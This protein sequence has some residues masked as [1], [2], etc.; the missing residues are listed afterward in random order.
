MD[1]HTTDVHYILNFLRVNNSSIA[2]DVVYVTFL[3]SSVVATFAAI[4]RKID[5]KL[6]KRITFAFK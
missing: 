2:Q 5:R 1:M 4:S 6:E 3:L